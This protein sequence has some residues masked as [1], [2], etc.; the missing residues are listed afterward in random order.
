[1]S[2]RSAVRYCVPAVRI[3]TSQPLHSHL[4]PY[5][6]AE[7]LSACQ[8]QVTN[9]ERQSSIGG[10]NGDTDEQGDQHLTEDEQLARRI[11]Q[12]ERDAAVRELY[13]A[14]GIGEWHCLGI[15]SGC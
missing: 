7:Q 6:H 3:S 12:E 14:Q 8:L 5:R 11:Q 15:G 10:V 2:L 1:M 9:S 4:L 13:A